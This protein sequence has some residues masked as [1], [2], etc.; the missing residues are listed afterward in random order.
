VSKR[1]PA[2]EDRLDR[3]DRLDRIDRIDRPD[4][5]DRLELAHA[6]RTPLTSALLATGLLESGGLGVL[7][8]AQREVVASIVED[9]D[10]LRRLV[11]AGLRIETLGAY[12]GPIERRRVGLAELATSAIEPLLAQSTTRQVR[13]ELTVEDALV[14]VDPI[15]LRWVV[16][17]LVGNALRFATQRVGVTVRADGG[18]ATL[19][20]DDDGPGIAPS[21]AARVF[22]RDGPGPTLYLIREIIEAHGGDVAVRTPDG[23]GTSFLV[24]LPRASAVGVTTGGDHEWQ[25]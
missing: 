7:N 3:L 1:K 25:R 14:L 8:D 9:L 23:V 19:T 13:I 2:G 6:L 10:R 18:D 5:I 11:D 4:R 22:D 20:V 12:A 15:K 24:R 16:A 17:S 21:V